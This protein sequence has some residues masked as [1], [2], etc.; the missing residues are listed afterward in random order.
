M[1]Q[2]EVQILEL[3]GNSQ[4]T[5]RRSQLAGFDVLATAMLDD[6]ATVD[7]ARGTRRV[8]LETG[9]GH[10]ILEQR[11]S[12]ADPARWL[13]GIWLHVA[14][15]RSDATV[16]NLAAWAD[17][18][19]QWQNNALLNASD[20]T[21]SLCGWALRLMGS[22]FLHEAAA[23]LLRQTNAAGTPHAEGLVRWAV[24]KLGVVRQLV[25]V[26]NFRDSE[27]DPYRIIQGADRYSLEK[28]LFTPETAI[29]SGPGSAE[30]QL[31][32][33]LKTM[34]HGQ[35]FPTGDT[36]QVSELWAKQAVD[37]IRRI[38][39]IPNA[40]R[41]VATFPDGSVRVACTVNR[42]MLDGLPGR[43][44]TTIGIVAKRRGIQV[45]LIR[46][47]HTFRH[48]IAML[49][50]EDLTAKQRVVSNRWGDVSPIN[51]NTIAAMITAVVESI[52]GILNTSNSNQ[53][54]D[55]RN[56]RS[57]RHSVLNHGTNVNQEDDDF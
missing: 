40:E 10:F 37:G 28:G 16:Y 54:A 41:Y 15:P 4:E 34:K 14:T 22:R 49:N 20:S 33:L 48:Y 30:L 51:S 27:A 6:Y 1:L 39:K 36:E 25:H 9:R 38:S 47:A 26:H 2:P 13:P 32:L 5:E 31:A 24:K 35:E 7:L 11:A 12:K 42:F 17:K 45:E 50:L 43:G 29:T 52:P 23:E 44:Q 8:E 3:A 53:V 55:A 56:V 57:F 19:P 46:E 18:V 21:V